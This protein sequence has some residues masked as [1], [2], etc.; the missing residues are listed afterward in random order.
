MRLPARLLIAAMLLCLALPAHAADQ[1]VKGQLLA[2][3]DSTPMT[4]DNE[5]IIEHERFAS[6][7]QEQVQRMNATIIG[8]RQSMHIFKGHDGLYRASYKAIDSSEVVCHVS[9]A[10]HD[11]RYFVGVMIYKELVMESVART[12]E[13]CR[14]GSFEPVAQTPQR[15]I[16]SS[17]RGGGWN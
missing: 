15:V 5:L 8:G 4:L 7:A 10:K 3:A 6:F 13:A 16:Y 2:S 12:A 1:A 9:R 17:K 14:R 11:P